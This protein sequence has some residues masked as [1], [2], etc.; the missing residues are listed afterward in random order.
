[1]H[2]PYPGFLKYDQTYEHGT[3]EFD[4]S[5]I[6]MVTPIHSAYPPF[7]QEVKDLPSPLPNLQPKHPTLMFV[8]QNQRKN[9]IKQIG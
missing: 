7:D 2:V 9:Q 4:L 3:P 1:M 6:A 8:C 5:I